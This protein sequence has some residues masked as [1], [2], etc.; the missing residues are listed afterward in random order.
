MNYPGGS[1]VLEMQSSGA[2]VHNGAPMATLAKTEALINMSIALAREEVK[3][4][5]YTELLALN[6]GIVIPQQ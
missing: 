1:Q 6:P 3:A 2:L 4:E 5:I